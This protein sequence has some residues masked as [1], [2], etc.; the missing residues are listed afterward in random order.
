MA[1]RASYIVR[2]RHQQ[3]DRRHVRQ[4]R[5]TSFPATDHGD[6]SSADGARPAT[7]C[8]GTSSAPTQPAPP[9]S[10][11][12]I[13]GLAL[14][15]ARRQHGWRRPASGTQPHLRKPGCWRRLLRHA[16]RRRQ[17]RRSRTWSERMSPERPRSG[18]A[19]IGRLHPDERE[20]RI[21]SLTTG[22]GNTIAFNGSVGVRVDSGT[23]N[24][25]V[26]NQIF[27]N[28]GLGIDLAPLGV[29]RERRGRRGH[30]RQQPAESP[31][32]QLGE[33]RRPQ[34]PGSRR[35]QPDAERPIPG[36][37]TTRTRSATRPAA[38][39]AR[40]SSASRRSA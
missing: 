15:L 6:S 10:P 25:I 4:R 21:G 1:S 30:R 22:V 36:P 16:G 8:S 17:F 27:S 14:S 33:D 34:C 28:A 31:G 11:S 37:V 24:A 40:R 3:H 35:A 29:T 23:G 18:T 13:N 39:K 20:Q 26:Y 19:R 12:L 7:R 5:A 9:P 38:A 32:T 2:R